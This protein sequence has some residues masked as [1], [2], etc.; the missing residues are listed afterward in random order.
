MSVVVL[1]AKGTFQL[2]DLSIETMLWVFL[3]SGVVHFARDIRS[4]FLLYL[5]EDYTAIS[6]ICSAESRTLSLAKGQ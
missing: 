4:K 1:K 5:R 3:D 2:R 6:K